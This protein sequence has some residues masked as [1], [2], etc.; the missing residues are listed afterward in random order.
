M[1]QDADILPPTIMFCPL[2]L[3]FHSLVINY[4]KR[5]APDVD[6]EVVRTLKMNAVFSELYTRKDF[7]G[8]SCPLESI[9]LNLPLI[10]WK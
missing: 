9:N 4:F 7:V 2:H 10:C 6:S 3:N 1:L 8:R 5:Y